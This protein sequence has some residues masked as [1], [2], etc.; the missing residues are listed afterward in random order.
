M[1]DDTRRAIMITN[2]A[3]PSQ[4]AESARPVARCL[5]CDGPVADGSD[6]HD[7]CFLVSCSSEVAVAVAL[8]HFPAHDPSYEDYYGSQPCTG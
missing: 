1:S 4:T 2:S 5:Y 3:E 6:E 7:E 8:M